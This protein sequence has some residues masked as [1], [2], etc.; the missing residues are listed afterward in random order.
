MASPVVTY[1]GLYLLQGKN[2]FIEFIPKTNDAMQKTLRDLNLSSF[3]YKG[4]PLAND[5]SVHV[6]NA[7]NRAYLLGTFDGAVDST[8]SN[9]A[10]IPRVRTYLG[11]LGIHF[12]T[13]F[14]GNHLAI[15][16]SDADKD[17]IILENKTIFHINNQDTIVHDV[18]GII[19]LD[20][21]QEAR[22]TF[23]KMDV[24]IHAGNKNYKSFVLS[25]GC[26][27]IAHNQHE[28]FIKLITKQFS[29][30]H[31]LQHTCCTVRINSLPN[32]GDNNYSIFSQ[33]Q[34]LLSKAKGV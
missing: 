27:T 26:P 4:W 12:T 25:R 7:A 17:F 18:R 32:K 31:L 11:R 15:A 13:S 16:L 8:N 19:T 14:N 6:W 29:I 10:S 9:Y 28:E 21:K 20:K 23:Q 30:E 34:N 24:E 2:M 22:N 5:H 3:S 33:C 1:K